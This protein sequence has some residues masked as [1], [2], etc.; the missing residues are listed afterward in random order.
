MNP[1]VRKGCAGSERLPEAPD[2][3]LLWLHELEA[4]ARVCHRLR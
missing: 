4:N 1:L 3:G 2:P